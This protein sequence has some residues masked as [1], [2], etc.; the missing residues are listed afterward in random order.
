MNYLLKRLINMGSLSD[1]R[2]RSHPADT[3]LMEGLDK[4]LWWVLCE[5]LILS[6]KLSIHTCWRYSEGHFRLQTLYFHDDLDISQI[7]KS[8]PDLQILGLYTSRFTKLKT[9]K[10]LHNA[11]Y[12]LPIVVMLERE[13]F[14]FI[15]HIGIFPSLCSA[16]R[17][18]TIHQV[19]A[20]SFCKDQGNSMVTKAE[21][22]AQLSIHL[23]DPSDIPSIYA[24]AK[25]LAVSFPQIDWLNVR[26][27]RRCEIVSFLFTIDD[28]NS[29]WSIEYMYYFIHLNHSRLKKSF[30]FSPICVG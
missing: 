29:T 1:F 12:F 9:L 28:Y 17:R 25:D 16:D 21:N 30:L 11:K 20:R 7:I 6:Q 15:G 22:I 5:I 13:S 14:V 18:A 10:E 19:L 26:F 3:E 24:L 2:A 8:Q 23:I 27:N 4:I